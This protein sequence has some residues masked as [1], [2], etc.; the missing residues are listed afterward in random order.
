M[1]ILKD[2]IEMR[3][4]RLWAPMLRL[5]QFVNC[6]PYCTS[7]NRVNNATFRNNRHHQG[8]TF[9]LESN[10]W[11]LRYLNEIGTPILFVIFIKKYQHKNDTGAFVASS[12]ISMTKVIW[13]GSEFGYH[14]KWNLLRGS[15]CRLPNVKEFSSL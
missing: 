15:L 11:R 3:F 5:F 13:L 2:L 10:D 14:R 4:S 9:C 1:T 6:W 12:P 8:C 7:R